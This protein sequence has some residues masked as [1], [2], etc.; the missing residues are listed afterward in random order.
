L[1]A[2]SSSAQEFF[3]TSTPTA[4]RFPSSAPALSS[5]LRAIANS[6]FFLLFFYLGFIRKWNPR[7][8]N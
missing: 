1:Q 7:S 6:L 4:F 5:G 3:S 8:D 2:V